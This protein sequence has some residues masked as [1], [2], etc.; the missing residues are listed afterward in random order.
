MY[1]N[2]SRDNE[3]GDVRLT[4]QHKTYYNLPCLLSE[5]VS[6]C[7]IFPSLYFYGTK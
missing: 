6:S 1:L 7:W 4:S 5:Q 2:H 3:V